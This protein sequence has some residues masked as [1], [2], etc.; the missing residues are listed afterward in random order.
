[1]HII[2]FI[3][4]RL[5][6]FNINSRKTSDTKRSNGTILYKGC[7]LSKV[8]IMAFNLFLPCL[9]S[10]RDRKSSF[11]FLLCH[12]YGCEAEA[13]W[14]CTTSYLMPHILPD[15]ILSMSDLLSGNWSMRTMLFAFVSDCCKAHDTRKADLRRTMDQSRKGIVWL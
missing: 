4:K 3:C 5:S 12:P 2:T 11:W 8:L 10:L 1:M 13:C 14:P 6:A 15:K 9:S 7:A